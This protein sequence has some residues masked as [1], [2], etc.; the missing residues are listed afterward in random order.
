MGRSYPEASTYQPAA[1]RYEEPE[2]VAGKRRWEIFLRNPGSP[3]SNGK[4]QA[5]AHQ[6]KQ[7]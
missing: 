2:L 6:E 7:R 1:G 5:V 4:H 3:D